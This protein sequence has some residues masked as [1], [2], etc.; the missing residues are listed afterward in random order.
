MENQQ[1]KKPTEAQKNYILASLD[2]AIESGQLVSAQAVF[3]YMVTLYLQDQFDAAFSGKMG[4]DYIEGIR[5]IQ[6]FL[7]VLSI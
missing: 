6:D 5:Q 7:A 2:H 1:V 4:E 3:T